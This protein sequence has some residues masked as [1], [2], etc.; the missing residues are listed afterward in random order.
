MVT[1]TLGDV[2]WFGGFYYRWVF[3]DVGLFLLIAALAILAVIGFI[4]LAVRAAFRIHDRHFR[5]SLAEGAGRDHERI[6]RDAQALQHTLARIGSEMRAIAEQAS[7]TIPRLRQN[8]DGSI[9]EY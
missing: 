9:S 4:W 1:S 2:R 8:P 3:V 5:T 6:R 7:H